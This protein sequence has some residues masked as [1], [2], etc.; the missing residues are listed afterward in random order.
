MAEKD[1][2]M[3]F[4][5]GT[6]LNLMHLHFDVSGLVSTNKTTIDG[7]E[8]PTKVGVTASLGLLF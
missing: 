5:L 3:A 2:K 8:Y 4:T 7:T 1:S 6:G